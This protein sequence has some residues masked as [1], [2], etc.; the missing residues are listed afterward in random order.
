MSAENQAPVVRGRC[1]VYFALDIGF[2]VDL[3]RCAGLIQ[4]AREAGGFQHH[5]RA[6]AYLNLH[7]APIHVS[8]TIEPIRVDGFRTGDRVTITIYDFGAVSVEYQLPF[9]GTWQQLGQLSSLLFGNRT[10][11][12]DARARAESVLAAIRPAVRRPM[13]RPE[14]EDYLIFSM[15]SLPAMPGA[16]EKVCDLLKSARD[17]RQA[18][19]QVL[20]SGAKKLSGQQRREELSRRISYYDDDLTIITWNA[21]LVV[22]ENMEDVLTVLELAN[23]QLRELHYLDD[24]L[25]D[26]LQESYDVQSK[27]HDVKASMQRI[28]E[29]MLDGQAFSEAVTNAFKPFPDAFLAR[30]YALA[31]QALGLENFDR[32][33]KD[34]LSLL[35]TL[36]TTLS[37]Q[38]D[39]ERSMRMELIVIVLI[40][41]EIIIGFADKLPLLF[42]VR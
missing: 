38:A 12:N 31:S 41:I 35:N 10:F 30:V 36:Y 7:P 13:V 27:L 37:D 8:Q 9:E 16:K 21:A 23:V 42:H 40:V 28:R 32:S 2:T 22:G 15:P 11:A 34:K 1:H 3:K 4:E 14:A 17:N 39:H 20:S 6:P 5:T 24:R 33:I 29:L 26:S 19:A 25:D 18:I